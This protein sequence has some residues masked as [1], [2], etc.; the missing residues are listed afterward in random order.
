MRMDHQEQYRYCRPYARAACVGDGCWSVGSW[1]DGFLIRYAWGS[2]LD[3]RSSM[4][5]M[6]RRSCF[7]DVV[8]GRESSTR[9]EHIL[10]ECSAIGGPFKR[11]HEF[12]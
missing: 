7:L 3:G 11:A 6:S 2:I 5:D 4:F 10:P 9:D 12:K 1:F 8:E